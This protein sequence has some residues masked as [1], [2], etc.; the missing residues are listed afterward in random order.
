LS[1]KDRDDLYENQ[2][3]PIASFP[4]EGIVIFGQKTLQ[5]TPS[6]LDRINVRRLMVYLKK[7]ISR[8]AS[9]LLF[10]QNVQATW[11]RFR[12]QVEPF[13]QQVK[14]GFG[15]QEYKVVL[16][17]TTTTPDLVDRNIMYA[18]IFIKPAKAL[19]FIAIDFVVTNQGASFDD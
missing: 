11:N 8:I 14:S 12:G 2:V 10:E 1:S 13:L 15:L 7:E 5:A 9:R 19:E 6:A 16:D 4:A 3:N 17:A 18:K